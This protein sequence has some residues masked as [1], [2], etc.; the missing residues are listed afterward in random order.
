MREG[1]RAEIPPYIYSRQAHVANKLM[2]VSHVEAFGKLQPY[3]PIY[4]RLSSV[5]VSE[6]LIVHSLLHKVGLTDD[7]SIY[8]A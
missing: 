6:V 5:I 2:I 8:P 1:S 7:L 3:P 4:V